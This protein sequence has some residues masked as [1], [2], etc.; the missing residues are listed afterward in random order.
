MKKKT[1]ILFLK[2]YMTTNFYMYFSENC[3]AAPTYNIAENWGIQ[4][5]MMQ[6]DRC[7]F[8]RVVI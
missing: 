6:C 7:D 8:L 5:L 2:N 1:N 4:T 3:V